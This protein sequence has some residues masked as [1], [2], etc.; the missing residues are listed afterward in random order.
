VFLIVAVIG[1]VFWVAGL[2]I[3]DEQRS[4]PRPAGSIA[5]TPGPVELPSQSRTLGLVLTIVVGLALAGG[6]LALLRLLRPER[7]LAG[8][9]RTWQVLAEEI[10]AGIADLRSMRDPRAAVIACYARMSRALL[11]SGLRSPSSDT[12]LERLHRVLAQRRVAE[13]SAR[14]LTG[15]FETAKFSDHG[16]DED[17]RTRAIDALLEVRAQ[18][19]ATADQANGA[20]AGVAAAAGT[21]P[22]GEAQASRTGPGGPPDRLPVGAP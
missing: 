5:P 11:A 8:E 22:G 21:A 10:D 16:V 7:H 13:P 2:L 20:Q 14:R 4:G 1:L 9:D 17:M 19:R 3:E 12:P 15:L 18:L 6:I